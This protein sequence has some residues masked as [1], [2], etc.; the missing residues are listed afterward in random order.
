MQNY[1]QKLLDND[2]MRVVSREVDPRHELSA[3]LSW[4]AAGERCTIIISQCLKILII[5]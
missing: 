4:F 1:I 2:E 3:V 5:P